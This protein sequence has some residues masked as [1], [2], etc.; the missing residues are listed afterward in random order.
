VPQAVDM[1]R[2]CDF[3]SFGRLLHETWTLK[4][5]LTSSISTETIDRIY[6]DALRA[7]ALGGKLLGAGGAG[8]MVFVVPIEHQPRVRKALSHLIN[9]PVRTDFTGST[10]IY[11]QDQ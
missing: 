8:F 10:I 7:G 11:R 1:L 3:D 2:H 4:R 9:V 6:D 5:A